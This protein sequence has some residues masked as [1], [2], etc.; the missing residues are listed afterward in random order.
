[1]KNEIILDK[2]EYGKIVSEINAVYFWKYKNKRK[3]IHMS[4][5]I[6]GRP[7]WYFFENYGFNAYRFVKKE[8]KSERRIEDE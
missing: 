6:D 3:G 7:F 5:D 8:G 1:M 4:Y 2:D